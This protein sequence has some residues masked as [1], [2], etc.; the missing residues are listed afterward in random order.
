MPYMAKE[1]SEIEAVVPNTEVVDWA[2]WKKSWNRRRPCTR[3]P[4]CVFRGPVDEA[5]V[6]EY[7]KRRANNRVRKIK[8]FVYRWMAWESSET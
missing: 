2:K 3:S 1:V 7:R 4:G 5:S 8:Q 6:L